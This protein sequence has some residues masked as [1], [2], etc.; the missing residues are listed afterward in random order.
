MIRRRSLL[1]IGGYR[2]ECRVA[3]DLDLF[4]RLAEIGR[5]ANLA[6]PLLNYREHSSKSSIAQAE[7]FATKIFRIIQEAR[8]RRGLEPAADSMMGK[9]KFTR[10]LGTIHQTWGWWALGPVM[11]RSPASTRLPASAAHRC[12]TPPGVSSTARSA[13]IEKRL[14]EARELRQFSNRYGEPAP[15]IC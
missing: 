3:E 10:D 7:A 6:E 4:L 11:C 15:E 14:E 5:I 12:L 9:L 13:A 8:R 2:P 1:E